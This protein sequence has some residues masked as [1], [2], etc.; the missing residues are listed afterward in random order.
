MLLE[1][2]WKPIKDFEGLYEIS[3]LGRVKSL[4]DNHGKDREHILKP[5]KDR[6]GYLYVNLRKNSKKKNFKI[7][8]L[9]AFAFVEGYFEGAE[10]DHIDTNREN[11]I[12][13]NLRFVTHK[14]NQ[15]NPLT[16]ERMSKREYTEEYKEK[17]SKNNSRKRKVYCI[18]LNKI[19]ES[20]MDAEKE[21]NVNHRQVSAVCKGKLKTHH[22]YRF[23]YYEDYLKLV[24]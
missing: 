22:G 1:E 5:C 23:M 21:L 15:N 18:E 24:E 2:I 8:R 19:F 7:H 14:E 11:N 20:I 4:K 10:V 13:T 12:W 17:L 9:V 6:D 3:N 16:K